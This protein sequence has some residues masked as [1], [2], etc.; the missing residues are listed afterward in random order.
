MSQVS[1]K[2]R[3]K[4]FKSFAVHALGYGEKEIEYYLIVDGFLTTYN[5]FYFNINNLSL[6]Q[7]SYIVKQ[8]LIAYSKKLGTGHYHVYK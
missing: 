8:L 6:M 4:D 2:V 1:I 3:L 5:T 7:K